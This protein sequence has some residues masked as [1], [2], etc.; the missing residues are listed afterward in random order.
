M[1]IAEQEFPTSIRLSADVLRRLE[2]EVERRRRTG[3]GAKDG[4][5][6]SAVVRDAVIAY[7]P[8]LEEMP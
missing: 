4:G 3:Y 7:L 6:R 2:Q 5:S 8:D 1:S